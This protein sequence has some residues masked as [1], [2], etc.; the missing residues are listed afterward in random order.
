MPS[1]EKSDRAP[2]PVRSRIDERI[3]EVRNRKAAAELGGGEGASSRQRKRGKLTARERLEKLLD[4]GSFHETDMLARHRSHGF[5]IEGKRPYGDG[6]VTGWGS[7]RGREGV[8]FRP[9]LP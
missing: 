8:V 7:A 9:G 6:V 4:P 1:F 2:V 5:G 3:E